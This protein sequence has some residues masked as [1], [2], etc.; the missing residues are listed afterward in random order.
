MARRKSSSN[1]RSGTP[2]YG[3][4]EMEPIENDEEV[5]V[6]SEDDSFQTACDLVEQG[7]YGIGQ[8]RRLSLALDGFN[9]KEVEA[10]LQRRA[11]VLSDSNNA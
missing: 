11:R 8:A 9:H 3:E 7:A 6:E 10:E 1:A 5:Q 4:V 2:N